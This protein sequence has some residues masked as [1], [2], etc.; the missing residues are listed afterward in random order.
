MV[1]LYEVKV[2]KVDAYYGAHVGWEHVT[3]VLSEE[4]AKEVCKEVATKIKAR[5][6]WW[7]EHANKNGE[8]NVVMEELEVVG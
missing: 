3:Y 2:E 6:E 8:P 1:K 5:R 4:K 7:M